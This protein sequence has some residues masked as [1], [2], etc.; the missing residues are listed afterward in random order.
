MMFPV[1]SIIIGVLLGLCISLFFVKRKLLYY[2]GIV[3][4]ICTAFFYI[5]D[6]NLDKYAAVCYFFILVMIFIKELLDEK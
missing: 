6:L 1:N 5:F 4:V 3:L 2:L